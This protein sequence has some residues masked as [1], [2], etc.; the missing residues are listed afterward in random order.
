MNKSNFLK[1]WLETIADK[2]KIIY[3]YAVTHKLDIAS[4]DDILKILQAV[5][6]ENANK[7]QAELYTKIMQLFKDRFKQTVEE[8]LEDLYYM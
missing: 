3:S 8:V 5:D 4:I 1:L 7:D 2:V 6:P